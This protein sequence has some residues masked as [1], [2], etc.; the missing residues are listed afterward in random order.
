MTIYGSLDLRKT[1]IT[2]LPNNL[3]VYGSASLS[4]TKLEALPENLIIGGSLYLSSTNIRT[5]PSSLVIG[6]SLDLHNTQ[7]ADLPDNLII[8]RWLD[9]SNTQIS[10]LPENL[11]VSSWLDIR[12][13]QIT[14]LPESLLVGD[15][16]YSD[17]ISIGKT[18]YNILKNG[19]YVPGKYLYVD[20]AL[21]HVKEEKVIQD[22][23]VYIGKISN[24]NV[25]SD[26]KHY[27]ICNLIKDGIADI[28]FERAKERGLEQY[29][30]LTLNSV[31]PLTDIVI[32]YRI[33][34]NSCKQ[35]AQNFISNIKDTSRNY[36][37][38]EVIQ[39]AKNQYGTK[40]FASFF[41]C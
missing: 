19:S 40:K 15:R 9:I 2:R 24:K 21:I 6:R 38:G 41:N 20:N 10:K 39:L 31:L 28:L 34:T 13:T 37:I 1:N 33:I 16:I 4:Q 35:E 17:P 3:K 5:I 14:T 11:V 26:G 8:G 25:V 29:K 23:T 36:S 7:I 12:N 22:Y 18:Q 30:E 32:I 27:V